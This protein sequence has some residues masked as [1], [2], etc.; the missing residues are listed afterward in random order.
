[1]EKHWKEDEF[2]AYQ[3]LNGINP[4]LIQHCSELPENFPVTD[5]MVET[6][7]QGQVGLQQEIKVYF[8][9]YFTSLE[10]LNSHDVMQ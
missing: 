7:L 1:M 5:D 4:M 3:F 9:N 8:M 6:S 10:Q 2:F